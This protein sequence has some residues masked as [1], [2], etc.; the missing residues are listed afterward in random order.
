MLASQNGSCLKHPNLLEN[1]QTLCN[2]CLFVFTK[3]ARS[4]ERGKILIDWFYHI[5]ICLSDIGKVT[6]PQPL[7]VK[8]TWSYLMYFI[9]NCSLLQV[10]V[11]KLI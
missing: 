5:L 1:T 4:D 3:R 8:M 11:P 2:N 9:E 6:T 7:R 10:V